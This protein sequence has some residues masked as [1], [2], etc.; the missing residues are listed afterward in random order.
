MTIK[1]DSTLHLMNFASNEHAQHSWYALFIHAATT[2]NHSRALHA[3]GC[4]GHW[5]GGGETS[6]QQ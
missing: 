3:E 2:G 4:L 6:T 5:Q 1:G